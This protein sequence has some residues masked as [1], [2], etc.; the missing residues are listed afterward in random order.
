MSFSIFRHAARAVRC[1]VVYETLQNQ[2]QALVDNIGNGSAAVWT[3]G[4]LDGRLDLFIA[5]GA[6]AERHF[7]RF[8]PMNKVARRSAKNTAATVEHRRVITMPLFTDPQQH[9]VARV[10]V[11]LFIEQ[12]RDFSEA[13]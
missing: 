1:A 13:L 5:N 6:A 3:D 4:N 11:R 10:G 9:R 7:L 12:S 8:T 2:W